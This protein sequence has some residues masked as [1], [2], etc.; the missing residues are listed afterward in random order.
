MDFISFAV[1][2]V[3]S[4]VV[5]GVLHYGL[6]YYV[7]EDKWSFIA[8]IMWG[9]LG[10]WLAPHLLGEWFEG[11]VVGDVHIIPAILGA[12]G[13]V[14]LG[15]DLFKSLA[16]ANSGSGSSGGSTSIG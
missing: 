6:K 3:I 7:S 2:L 14:I 15:T 4:I 16:A 13:I 5:S 1:L 12:A 11:A 9:Y 10:A 8:K